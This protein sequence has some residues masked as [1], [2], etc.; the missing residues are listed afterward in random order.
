MGRF[1]LFGLEAGLDLKAGLDLEAGLDLKVGSIP[2]LLP[3]PK[4][5]FL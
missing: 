3:S 4:D 1:N 2:L 5:W